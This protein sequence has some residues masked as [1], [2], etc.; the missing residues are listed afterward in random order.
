MLISYLK[1]MEEGYYQYIFQA[2]SKADTN[3]VKEN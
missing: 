2:Y 3:K 1:E